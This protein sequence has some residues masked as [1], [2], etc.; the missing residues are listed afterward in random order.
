MSDLAVHIS[1][2]DFLAQ[3][4]IRSMVRATYGGVRPTDRR[5]A[6]RYYSA[7]ELAG[8]PDETARMALGVGN[9]VRHAALRPGEDVIDLGSGGGIDCLLAGRLVGP[10]GS[11]VGV[12]FLPEM[13]DRVLNLVP[14]K[15]AALAEMFRVLRPGGRFQLADIILQRSVSGE[16]KQDVSL[17]TG[18]IAGGL[19][20]GEVRALVESAGFIDVE[21]I[22]G[23]DIFAGA[24]QSSSAAAFGTRGAGIRAH[25]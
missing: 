25:R 2:G 4:A 16:S 9:P 21:V 8:L 18:C 17:W 10:T 6:G 24:P 12:D 23:S 15:A 19:V 3:D 22:H 13:V 1:D 7:E 5:V 11:V 14:D 20:E